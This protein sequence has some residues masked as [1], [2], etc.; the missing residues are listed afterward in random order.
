MSN[1]VFDSLVSVNLDSVDHCYKCRT[2]LNGDSLTV[3]YATDC[4]WVK[5][6]ICLSENE[7]ALYNVP[8]SEGLIQDR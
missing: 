5:A 1:R 8:G 3:H 7:L 6:R 4:L 2:R